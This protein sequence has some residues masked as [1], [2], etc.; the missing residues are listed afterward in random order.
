MEVDLLV[1]VDGLERIFAHGLVIATVIETAAVLGPGGARELDPLNDLIRVGGGGDLADPPFL[2]VG[3]TR[4]GAVGQPAAIGRDTGAGKGDGAIVGQR[5]RIQQHHRLGIERGQGVEHGLILQPVVAGD[6][7][8][9]PFVA[10]QAKALVVPQFGH[11][12][13]DLRALRYLLQIILSQGVLGFDPLP[14]VGGVQFLQP[15]VGIS[16]LGAVIVVDLVHGSSCRISQL[17]LRCGDRRGGLG[18]GRAGHAGQGGE[19]EQAE[20]HGSFPAID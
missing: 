8:A 6:E 5:V 12:R 3:S 10:G 9:I 20:T 7:V 18:R 13:V 11:A 2:P 14:G 17:L 16:D 1:F 19:G 4:G 15:T